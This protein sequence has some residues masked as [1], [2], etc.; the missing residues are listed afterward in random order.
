M[1]EQPPKA[2]AQW[3]ARFRGDAY[4]YGTEPNDFLRENAERL[5]PRGR[6]LS[7]GEGEGRNAA[8]L[9]SLGHE[10]TAVDASAVGLAKASRLAESRG[11]SVRAIVSDLADYTF[12]PS[13]WGGAILIFCHL[14][15]ELRKRVH[16]GVVSALAPGGVVLLLA[17]TPR[18]LEYGT[19]GPRV[20]EL[21]Y[22]AESLREDF[23]GLELLHLAERTREVREGPLHTGTGAVVELVA[24]RG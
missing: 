6:V 16:R 24:R 9:A 21:L 7:L 22:S 18:Q 11:L 15:P 1:T 3:D 12:E 10:V 13:A 8:F 14:P 23:A 5:P 19:G 2:A 20:P 17:Y 4:V